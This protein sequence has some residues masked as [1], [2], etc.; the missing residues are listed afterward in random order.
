MSPPS[1]LDLEADGWTF[2]GSVSDA[3]A[4]GEMYAPFG[5]DWYFIDAPRAEGELTGLYSVMD[6]GCRTGVI[7]QDDGGGEPSLQGTWCDENGNFAQV[8]PVY[9]IQVVG[10]QLHVQVD[11]GPLGLGIRDLYVTRDAGL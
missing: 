10:G 8:T 9:P 2:Q 3:W 4:Y 5:D 1:S 7:V 11:L 6:S